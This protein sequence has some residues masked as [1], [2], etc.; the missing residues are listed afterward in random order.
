M[1]GR[2][3]GP[4]L[5][6]RDGKN[7]SAL[8]LLIKVSPLSLRHLAHRYFDSA[9]RWF[10]DEVGHRIR[11]FLGKVRTRLRTSIARWSRPIGRVWDRVC[12]ACEAYTGRARNRLAHDLPKTGQASRMWDQV[13]ESGEAFYK[14][15]RTRLSPAFKWVAAL[16][17]RIAARSGAISD[18]IRA[19]L[20]SLVAR[21]EQTGFGYWRTISKRPVVEPTMP[22][23]TLVPE[24]QK[25]RRHFIYIGLAV[26]SVLVI[27]ASGRLGGPPV[28]H[29]IKAWQAR[30][31]AKKADAYL[32]QHNWYAARREAFTAYQLWSE[33]PNASRAVARVLGAAG[34]P[35][36]LGFWKRFA[37]A[38]SLSDDDL[39]SE[40]LAAITVGE[41]DIARGDMAK[42]SAKKSRSTAGDELIKAR[43]ALAD[44]DLSKAAAS[45]A[46][47]V[48]DP[49]A[50][51]SDQVDAAATD[52]SPALGLPAIAPTATAIARD[53]Q[54]LEAI[55]RG[56]SDA[57]LSALTVL[58]QKQLSTPPGAP[59][60]FDISPPELEK[61][62]TSHPHAR[63][64]QKLL[65]MDL[66]EHADPEQHADLVADAIAQFKDSD[67]A[68]LG[69]LATWLNS[70]REYE[71]ELATIPLDRALHTRDLFIQHLD[72]LGALGRWGEVK[73]L[74]DSE[75]YPLDPVETSMYLAH[76][77]EELHE[78]L[79]TKNNWDRALQ[80]TQNDANKLM[81]LGQYAFRAR[82]LDVAD[83]AFTAAAR[84]MPRLRAAQEARLS[85]AQ[86]MRDTKKL[87]AVLHEMLQLWPNDEAVENDEA[88]TRLLLADPTG[89]DY[90]AEVISIERLAQK[91]VNDTPT[92]LPHRILLAL[93]RLKQNRATGALQVYRDITI[94]PSALTAS[95]LAVHAAV[96][97][98]NGE[99]ADAKKEVS[100]IAHDQ[101]LPEE[102]ALIERL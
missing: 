8:P 27:F 19:A 44:G 85:V 64:Q 68:Q 74:L 82:K 58:A 100:R 86:A 13:A 42:L 1:M 89:R 48:N 87:H 60:P 22:A 7:T 90:S 76:A 34:Q 24:G 38:R 69:A 63:A 102:N 88:Y 75:R 70:K 59:I 47:V 10:E 62:L 57:A 83:E 55:A 6:K 12:D 17:A 67:D 39:R 51:E 40:A 91:L 11:V 31:H 50:S 18:K 21:I 45:L 3:F 2:W 30:R 94:P 98:A 66:A 65:A 49:A 43:L 53:W 79:A 56:H 5:A 99:V 78:S 93:A 37:K 32:A 77:S 23:E 29:H 46:R 14:D 20:A 84:K 80:A 54:K 28:L 9:A 41:Y 96:L 4:A 95:A 25:Q 72:A 33:E 73:Q 92:S 101:L 16:C 26:L 61:M 97:A 71:K 81:L 35:E 52:L 15:V 36:A